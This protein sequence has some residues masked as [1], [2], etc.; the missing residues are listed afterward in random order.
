MQVALYSTAKFLCDKPCIQ[1]K[2][3]KEKKNRNN[4]GPV[5]LENKSTYEGCRHELQRRMLL[6]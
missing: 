4:G 6:R 2:N 1:K 3:R 5:K